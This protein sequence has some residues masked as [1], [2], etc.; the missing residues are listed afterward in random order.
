[1]VGWAAIAVMVIE[2]VVRRR[3]YARPTWPFA[4]G[5]IVALI[6]ATLNMLVHT[7]DAWSSVMPWGVALS[8]VI[9]LVLLVTRWATREGY[10]VARAE[11]LT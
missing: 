1:V 10:F 3:V 11:V 4:I 8:A 5:N 6:L 9:V 7:R 2:A